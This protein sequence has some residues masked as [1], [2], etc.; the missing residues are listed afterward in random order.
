MAVERGLHRHV[1]HGEVRPAGRVDVV[2]ASRQQPHTP[3]RL[4]VFPVDVQQGV[5]AQIVGLAQG[6]VAAQERRAADRRV[7]LAEQAV[8]LHP[9]VAAGAVAQRHVGVVARQIDAPVGA[10]DADLDVRMPDA[11]T[12]ESGHQP[13][14][15]E[16]GADADGQHPALAVGAHLL[17]PLGQLVEALAERRQGRLAG[18]GEAQRPGQA[19]EQGYLEQLFERLDLVADRG[20]RDVQLGRRLGEAE[21]PADRFEGPESVQ[22]RGDRAI[23]YT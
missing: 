5:V 20:R 22:G 16:R 3:A 7:D 18:I 6:V 21:V 15:A 2:Q 10:V 23:V 11:E 8:D 4:G 14:G 1:L 13:H 9:L 17:D 19:A 12:L